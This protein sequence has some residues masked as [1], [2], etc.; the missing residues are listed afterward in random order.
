MNITLTLA[1]RNLWRHRRRTWLTVGAMVFCN[2]LL[3]FMI[4]LQFG[5]YRMMIENPLKLFT[6]QL[7]IQAKDYLDDPKLRHSF[8]QATTLAKNIRATLAD[9]DS[10]A[11][12]VRGS[13]FA[14]A[15]S[16][17]R[18]FGMQVT[19]V[20]PQWEPGVSSL[21]NS[22][23]QGRYLQDPNAEEIV[24]GRGLA[25]NLKVSVGDEL[26]LLGS[27]R[28]GSF[29]AGFAKIVGIFDSGMTD[30]DRAM[31]QMPLGYFQTLF[32][33]QGQAHSIV[34]SNDSLTQVPAIQARIDTIIADKPPLISRDWDALMPGIK[35][36]IISDLVG[37]LFTYLVL[38]VLVAFSV[39]N[40]QLMSVLERTKEF[41]ILTALGV[42]PGQLGR[43]IML[44]TLLMALL[45]MALGMLFGGLLVAWLSQVGIS[46]PGMEEMAE[47]FAMADRIFPELNILTLALGPSIVF[48]G[49]LFAAVYP[50]LRLLRLQPVAAMRAA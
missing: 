18:S 7:Q 44:E 3:V 19:G 45:G 38:A 35:Q 1:W 47:R 28:D 30:M 21:A 9:V 39:L 23:K 36:S 11:V 41:G 43:L 27:G 42:R 12:A 8:P 6:G 20:Q 24:I 5:A 48:I 50:S 26:T 4:S 25:R 10:L 33:M 40:T 17:E 31:A 16:E 14:L 29:A 2:T 34:I 37:N 32:A 46:M 49:C 13:A 22:V 15:S